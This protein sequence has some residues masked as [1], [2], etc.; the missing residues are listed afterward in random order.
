ME[1]V[2]S[3]DLPEPHK[4][5]ELKEIT[6]EIERYK[7][8]RK[9]R[10]GLERTRQEENARTNVRKLI[11]RGLV[12]IAKEVDILEKYLNEKTITTRGGCVYDPIDPVEWDLYPPDSAS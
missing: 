7:S 3:S 8:S 4:A 1:K 9:D 6:N 12:K 10:K 5:I 2:S 11:V